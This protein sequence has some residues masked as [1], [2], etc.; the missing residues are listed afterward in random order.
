MTH[1]RET[2]QRLGTISSVTCF[3][4]KPSKA[5]ADLLSSFDDEEPELSGKR[6]ASKAVTKE[7]VGS[8][9]KQLSKEWIVK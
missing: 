5:G 3:G 6:A 9:S 4:L 7:T 8:R 2:R 1:I